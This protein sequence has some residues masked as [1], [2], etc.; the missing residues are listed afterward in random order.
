MLHNARLFCLNRSLL[1]SI[2]RPYHANSPSFTPRNEETTSSLEKIVRIGWLTGMR[3]IIKKTLWCDMHH[4][5]AVEGLHYL[6]VKC[7]G[8]MLTR[9]QLDNSRIE[10][11]DFFTVDSR[12]YDMVDGIYYKVN[13]AEVMEIKKRDRSLD[14]VDIIRRGEK[15]KVK[16]LAAKWR[17]EV[18]MKI[19]TTTKLFYRKIM[20]SD[21]PKKGS[22]AFQVMLQL[23][24]PA[25]NVYMGT[26]VERE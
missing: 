16:G 7:N 8:A 15:R 4:E 17:F 13:K 10:V 3:R 11:G 21:M 22:E 26:Q 2:P 12:V 6:R 24:Q 5:E 23:S 18:K 1:P 19:T 25:D 14:P 9:D 20:Y